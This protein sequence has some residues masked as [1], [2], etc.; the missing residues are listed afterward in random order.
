MHVNTIQTGL[1]FVLLN[2][3]E[4]NVPLTSILANTAYKLF[5]ID[6]ANKI[7]KLLRHLVKV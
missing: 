7:S 3:V 6:L 5:F 4:R 2:R 1:F